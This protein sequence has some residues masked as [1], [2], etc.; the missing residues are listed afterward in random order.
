M[1]L[2]QFILFF[3]LSKCKIA[4]VARNGIIS[5]PQTAATTF[6]FSSVFILLL[7]YGPSFSPQLKPLEPNYKQ[8]VPKESMFLIQAQ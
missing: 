4:S 3:K 7:L 1:I 6:A 5:F 8:I 2:V